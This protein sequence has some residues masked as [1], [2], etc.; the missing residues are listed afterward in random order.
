[1]ILLGKIS[2]RLNKHQRCSQSERHRVVNR[3]CWLSL[4]NW[5]NTRRVEV[6]RGVI[7]N[8]CWCVCYLISIVSTPAT[9][10]VRAWRL[11][12]GGASMCESCVYSKSCPSIFVRQINDWSSRINWPN[13]SAENSSPSSNSW[14]LSQSINTKVSCRDLNKWSVTMSRNISS[15]FNFSKPS[16]PI[17]NIT[18][19]FCWVTLLKISKAFH[20]TCWS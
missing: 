2:E 19:T 1:M 10:F 14:I 8:V 4:S 13:I 5:S 15:Y 11:V 17:C 18:S 12:N 9:S 16:V 7:K 20:Y 3:R 6:S